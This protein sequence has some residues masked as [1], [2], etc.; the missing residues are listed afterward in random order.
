MII[1]GF[2]PFGSAALTGDETEGAV[3]RPEDPGATLC[4]VRPCPVRDCRRPPEGQPKGGLIPEAIFSRSAGGC[5]E[6][7]DRISS[8]LM[9]RRGQRG[10]NLLSGVGFQPLR[11]QAQSVAFK[12]AARPERGI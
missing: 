2:R 3:D 1:H 5:P 9:R 6:G 12:R 4:L 11:G 10:S 7:E 8:A